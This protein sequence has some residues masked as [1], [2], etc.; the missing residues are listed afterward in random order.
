[1]NYPY[2]A[3]FLQYLKHENL[4]DPT[5]QSYDQTLT[6]LFNY[7]TAHNRG[8]TNNPIIDNIFDRDITD[9]LA[10]LLGES[11]IKPTTYNKLL[12]QINRYFKFLFT[13]QLTK[14]LPT[15][16]LHG[17]ALK[18]NQTLN[19]K[20][21]QLLPRILV[22][23]KIH[24]YTKLTLFLI[25]KGYQITEFM[26]SGFYQEWNQITTTTTVEHQFMQSFCN[27]IKPLQQC[28]H[29]QDIFLK[30]RL[31]LDAPLLSVPGLHKYLKP[32][33]Q[34]VGFDLT[35]QKLRQSYILQMLQ[36]LK[37]QPDTV[38]ETKLHLNPASL[39]YYQHLL[40]S[41]L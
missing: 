39:S 28:Q 14:K 5:L 8:Y 25:S 40:T 30:Q 3:N 31:A 15:L 7:L 22:D 27:Y 6:E 35:P 4:A 16:E 1:M 20:W 36:Q 10:M 32:D 9:Y 33:S 41:L 26:Q 38:I 21:L 37:N 17:K 12:S 11:Q 23:D 13:H 19:L 24:P 34:Y 18:S 2:Q 29:S